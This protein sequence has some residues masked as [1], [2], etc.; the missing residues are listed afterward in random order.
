M[1]VAAIRSTNRSSNSSPGY[2]SGSDGSLNG[3]DQA[4]DAGGSSDSEDNSSG[5]IHLLAVILD[6]NPVG[7]ETIN[8]ASEPN[9]L[10]DFKSSLE[11]IMVF[12]NTFLADSYNNYLTLIA[13][14]PSSCDFIYP[15]EASEESTPS[16][17]ENI[18]NGS[19]ST[20]NKT[21]LYYTFQHAHN[22]IKKGIDEFIKS[23]E[24]KE[25]SGEAFEYS[26]IASALSRAS[27]YINKIVKKEEFD[28]VIPRVLIL[29]V[30]SDAPIHYIPMMNA[31]FS[32]QRMGFPIDTIKLSGGDSMF[33]QQAS[34]ITGGRFLDLRTTKS[35]ENESKENEN[36]S[37]DLTGSL[38]QYLVVGFLPD[39]LTRKA[40]ISP[41]E[42]GVDFRAAC[43]CHKKVVDVGYV[44]SV[45]L[46]I[47]CQFYTTCSTCKSKFSIEKA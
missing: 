41:G 23:V 39:P 38:L 17:E 22:Q 31:I 42:P 29:S 25:I 19:E 32:A 26:S 46:S 8:E 30:S 45:C 18:T 9:A 33:L 1:S 13:A 27:C 47:F 14:H 4:S 40:L 20:E 15:K 6:L 11:Q 28:K 5:V 3:Q 37:D 12:I 24:T 43:F 7:W 36:G 34:H 35:T 16:Q 2:N 10:P 21:F 44:C